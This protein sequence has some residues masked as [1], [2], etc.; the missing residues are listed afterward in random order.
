MHVTCHVVQVEAQALDDAVKDTLQCYIS[1]P[2]DYPEEWD[3]DIYKDLPLHAVQG[4]G[5]FTS[6]APQQPAHEPV[7]PPLRDRA[8]CQQKLACP[9]E[10]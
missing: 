5:M 6:Y 2:E 9:A 7:L 1:A 8:C 4:V 10:W 3:A